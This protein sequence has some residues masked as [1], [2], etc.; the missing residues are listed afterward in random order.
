MSD[1]N[2][3]INSYTALCQP[4]PNSP[5]QVQSKIPTQKFI[6][7]QFQNKSNTCKNEKNQFRI[8]GVSLTYF[9]VCLQDLYSQSKNHWVFSNSRSCFFPIKYPYNFFKNNILM[10]LINM[11]QNSI[12]SSF[13]IFLSINYA[14]CFFENFQ[15]ST[16]QT[17]IFS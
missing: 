6:V 2:T 14:T 17:S 11:Q 10:N 3:L 15:F 7:L 5:S 16:V 4:L 12:F 8:S 1:I 9:K 13:A